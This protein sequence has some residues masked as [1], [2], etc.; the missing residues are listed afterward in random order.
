MHLSEHALF[1]EQHAHH[2]AWPD[3]LH[4]H[5]P[6]RIKRQFEDVLLWLHE[7]GLPSRVVAAETAKRQQPGTNELLQ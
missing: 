5:V 6:D 1:E 4:R 2:T 7:S 3:E